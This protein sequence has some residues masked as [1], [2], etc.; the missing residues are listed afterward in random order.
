MIGPSKPLLALG[1]SRSL[2]MFRTQEV[3]EWA[4]IFCV[5][6]A[7]FRVGDVKL[8]ISVMCLPTYLVY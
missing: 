1:L 4:P 2:R 8:I 3:R 5:P 7:G 6:S